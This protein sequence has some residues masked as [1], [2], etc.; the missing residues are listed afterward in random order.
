MEPY[1]LSDTGCVRTNNEDRIILEP[2]LG[3]FAVCDGMGGHQ[4]GDLAAEIATTA[5]RQYVEASADRFEITWPFGYRY[6][7]SID[8]NRMATAIRLANRL[9]WRTSEQEL[10]YAGMGTTIAAI[11]LDGLHLV[12]GNVGDSRI[13]L[14]RK[15]MFVTLSVDDTIIASM[16]QRGTMTPETY[17]QHPMRNVLTQAAGS[18]EQVEV[19]LHESELQP[20]DILLLCTDGLHAVVEEEDVRRILRN[21]STPEEQVRRLIGAARTAGAPDNVSAV[22][23]TVGEGPE[24]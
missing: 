8:A 5:L 14:L 18:Q 22:V 11:L 23:V 1:G 19:H 15:E 16:I 21:S 13:Y 4:R 17:R 3:F 6:D 7:L 12:A 20:E 2:R 9:V 24:S 10:A